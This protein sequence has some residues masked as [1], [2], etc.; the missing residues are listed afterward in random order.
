M[1]KIV[2]SNK[3]YS[4]SQNLLV[5]VHKD[6]EVKVSG[7]TKNREKDRADAKI[8]EY[9][10]QA[11]KTPKAKIP[12]NKLF[13][14]QLQQGQMGQVG[15][16]LF[17]FSGMNSYQA[18]QTFEENFTQIINEIIRSSLNSFYGE[19]M[20]KEI[21]SNEVAMILGKELQT[22]GVGMSKESYRKNAG[23]YFK[24]QTLISD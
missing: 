7:L 21:A 23:K 12:L 5:D 13:L 4:S 3:T 20:V 1:G 14:Q 11:V 16:E 2:L 9:V 6:L 22:S 24:E 17:N 10:L 19:E 15:K 18:G 8:I